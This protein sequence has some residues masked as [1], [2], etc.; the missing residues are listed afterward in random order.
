MIGCDRLDNYVDMS[1]DFAGKGCGGGGFFLFLLHF[2][3]YKLSGIIILTWGEHCL[4]TQNTFNAGNNSD[5]MT[6]INH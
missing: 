2:Q 5:V 6:L 4:V 1:R 3:D